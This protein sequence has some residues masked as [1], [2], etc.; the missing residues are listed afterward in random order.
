M[1]FTEDR[2]EAG[3]EGGD[4]EMQCSLWELSKPLGPGPG[5]CPGSGS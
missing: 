1:D 4:Q 5:S 3:G 2:Q